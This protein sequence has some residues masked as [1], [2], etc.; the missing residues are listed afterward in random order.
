MLSYKN[1]LAQ[2]RRYLDAVAE[3]P[4]LQASLFLALSLIL[5]IILLVAALRPTLITISSLVGEISQLRQIEAQLNEKIAQL[6][7]ASSLYSQVSSRLAVLDQA[8]PTTAQAG[9][10]S[11][12]LTSTALASGINIIRISL[13]DI[14]ISQPTSESIGFSLTAGGGYT[15]L[16]QWLKTVENL[17]R[18]TLLKTARFNSSQDG[19]L[20]II[21]TGAIA[22]APAYDQKGD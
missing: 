19:N 7:A 15:Q 16:N 8:L 17:R 20:Q 4:L 13:T 2:Y 18:L 6:N 5:I 10:W 3:Q 21:V 12:T 14:E 1:S 22:T 9:P 11:Q